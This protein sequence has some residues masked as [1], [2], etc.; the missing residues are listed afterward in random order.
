VGKLIPHGDSISISV[1]LVDARNDNHIWADEYDRKMADIA[2]MQA[3][4]SKDIAEKLRPKLNGEQKDIS[5]S[6]R[7]RMPRRMHFT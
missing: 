2:G 6:R 1:E 3:I 5:Q 7:P 4:I